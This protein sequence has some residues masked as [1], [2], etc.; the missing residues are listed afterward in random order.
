MNFGAAIFFPDYSMGPAEPGRALEE[1][2]FESPLA[3]G[4]AGCTVP[5]GAFSGDRRAP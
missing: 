2:G 4:A 1:R 3:P 5:L